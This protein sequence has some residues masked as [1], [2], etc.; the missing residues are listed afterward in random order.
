ML[1]NRPK[2]LGSD[3]DGASAGTNAPTRWI[4][5]Q[6]GQQSSASPSRSGGLAGAVRAS[7]DASALASVNSSADTGAKRSR[8][9]CPKDNASWKA[10]ANS[11][12]YEL[13]LE[14]DRNQFIVVALGASHIGSRP[15]P[16]AD[17]ATLVTM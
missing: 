12:R 5:V 2:T 14:R 11:A 10:T 13:N 1:G 17:V 3:N 16:A 7:L 4:S 15:I 6:I 8:C 9:T